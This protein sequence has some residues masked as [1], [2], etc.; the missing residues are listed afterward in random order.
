MDSDESGAE[1][2]VV[3]VP[4]LAQSHMNQ[5]LHFSTAIAGRGLSVSFVATYTHIQQVR[6]RFQGC[7]LQKFNI[8][9]EELPMPELPDGEPNAESTHMF[10]S[11]LTSLYNCG[12]LLRPQMD[13]FLSKICS[14]NT[15]KVVMVYDTQMGWVQPLADKY[16]IPA[17]KFVAVGIYSALWFTHKLTGTEFAG[18][19]FSS[20]KV[21]VLRTMTEQHLRFVASMESFLGPAKGTILSTFREI[22]APFIDLAQERKAFGDKPVWT[23]GPLLPHQLLSEEPAA[24][25]RTDC[26]CMRWLDSHS[27]AS[28]LYVSFG[29]ACSLPAAQ[30]REI[31]LGLERSGQH[32]LWALRASDTSRFSSEADSN[33]I[34]EFL[35]E[36]YESRIRGRGFIVTKWAPQLEIVFHKSTGGFLTHC[37][38]GSTVESICAGVPIVAWPLHSDNFTNAKLLTCE[39]KTGVEVKEWS[40]TEEYEMVSA[41]EVQVAVKRLMVSEEGMQMRKRAQDLRAQTRMAI[42]DGGS[43]SNQLDSLLDHFSQ[44][45]RGSIG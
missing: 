39:L 20:L 31:A 17:Y 12:D 1:I 44:Q 24:T 5:F 6:H 30:I 37:G 2:H 3:M 15:K 25:L 35:P 41:E 28:V 36:G 23:V 43:L 10:P 38:W 32:F 26:E 14:S 7:D 27:P 19:R 4:L 29:S 40:N 11:H 13:S 16:E 42:A 21:P 18:L 34:C 22:E 45:S 33:G 8:H 9:F